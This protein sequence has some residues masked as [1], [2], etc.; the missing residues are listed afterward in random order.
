MSE[1]QDWTKPVTY[2]GVDYSSTAK[3]RVAVLLDELEA[4]W[5][6][7]DKEKMPDFR[8]KNIQSWKTYF[9]NGEPDTLEL[10]DLYIEVKG[11]LRA[12]QDGESTSVRMTKFSQLN[13]LLVINHLPAIQEMSSL[14]TLAETIISMYEMPLKGYNP[15]KYSPWSYELITCELTDPVMLVAM[16]DGTVNIMDCYE[17]LDEEIAKCIDKEKT[18]AAYRKAQ[19]Y[20]FKSFTEP[21]KTIIAEE[22]RI[23]S[24]GLV[25]KP[26]QKKENKTKRIHVI[27]RPSLYVKVKRTA[28]ENNV[29]VNELINQMLEQFLEGDEVV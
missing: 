1:F 5:E 24:K 12:D 21:Q 19:I 27:T 26:I 10:N 11:T 22:L 23:D 4:D 6:R 14:T 2:R 9:P 16:K 29:S 15:E 20:R 3:G 7:V 8:V 18:V 28:A 25:V 17:L 13:A